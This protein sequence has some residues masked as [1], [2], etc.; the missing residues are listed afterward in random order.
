MTI[1]EARALIHGWNGSVTEGEYDWSVLHGGLE[2]RFAA[3][4][5][6]GEGAPEETFVQY[7]RGR[8]IAFAKELGITEREGVEGLDSAYSWYDTIARWY[9]RMRCGTHKELNTL[10]DTWLVRNYC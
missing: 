5:A 9:E 8:W 6:S 2:L 4:I 10:F 3:Y 1:E 7:I